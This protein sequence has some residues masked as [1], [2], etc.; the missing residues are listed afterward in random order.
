MG[1]G[2]TDLAGRPRTGS[3]IR[4]GVMAL[5]AVSLL[6]ALVV[7]ASAAPGGNNGKGQVDPPGQ[8]VDLQLLAFNDYHGHVE[9]DDAGN[10]GEEP[11]G[12]GQYLATKLK[13]LRA[14]N[15]YSLTVAAGDLIGGSPFFSGLFHDE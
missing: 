1:S 8:L 6:V 4:L 9:P 12:G 14:G 13:E 2:R 11:A 5:M 7:P 10:I 15:K 3:R